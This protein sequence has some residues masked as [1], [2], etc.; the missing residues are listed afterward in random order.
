MSDSSDSRIRRSLIV[1]YIHIWGLARLQLGD[2]R[3][4]GYTTRPSSSVYPASYNIYSHHT[5]EVQFY[6][7]YYLLSKD[8]ANVSH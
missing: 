2:D 3:H 4:G 7:I 5:F 8:V 6:S 1:Y